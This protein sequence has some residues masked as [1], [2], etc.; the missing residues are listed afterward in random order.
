MKNLFRK[1]LLPL[2]ILSSALCGFSQ[3]TSQV[4]SPSTVSFGM[5]L[6]LQNPTAIYTN[7]QV[8]NFLPMFQGGF[9]YNSNG[10]GPGSAN[11]IFVT[12]LK[13]T[14][15]A[16]VGTN[17]LNLHNMAF[18]NTAAV[19]APNDAVGNPYSLLNLKVLAIQN[20]GISGAPQETNMLIVTT[21]GP[22]AGWT[23]YYGLPNLIATI[24]GPST[25]SSGVPNATNTPVL[26]LANSGD[27][28]YYVGAS[29]ANSLLFTNPGTGTLLV[30][31]YVVGST[32]Q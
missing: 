12:Q 17:V 6:T 27:V 16:L 30:N 13:I 29:L 21:N 9:S 23:N 32:N 14:N 3:T 24:P 8:F 20:L 31:V 25:N 4:V 11:Q 19:T 26:V 1:I 2:A 28:G 5:G 15:G 7:K 10:V 18:S 22:T